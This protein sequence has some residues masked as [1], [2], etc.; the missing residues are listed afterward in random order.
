MTP[1][2]DHRAQRPET[3]AA[4]GTRAGIPLALLLLATLAV[5]MGGSGTARAVVCCGGGGGDTQLSVLDIH[6]YPHSA[7]GTTAG[8]TFEESPSVPPYTVYGS[9]SCTNGCQGGS[10]SESGGVYSIDVSGLVSGGVYSY[11]ITVSAPSCS[12]CVSGKATGSFQATGVAPTYSYDQWNPTDTMS[13]GWPS[14]STYSMT[15]HTMDYAPGDIVYDENYAQNYTSTTEGMDNQ[16]GFYFSSVGACWPYSFSVQSATVEVELVDTTNTND[17]FGWAAASN[18]L[19]VETSTSGQSSYQYSVQASGG[20]GTGS[21]GL[22]LAYTGPTTANWGVSIADANLGGGVW[23]EGTLSVSFPGSGTSYVNVD[24]PTDIND[25]LAKS[26]EWD[27]FEVEFYWSFTL[28]ESGVGCNGGGSDW[29][30]TWS[31]GNIQSV[32]G[33]TG[34]LSSS[35]EDYSS[36]ET[37][38]EGGVPT[39]AYK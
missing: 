26:Y 20:P 30:N 17:N 8:I 6:V 2:G 38:L 27:H 22:G 10:A 7:A 9:V 29:C 11:T 14:S 4:R 31:G 16:V 34:Y 24:W 3:N 1:K 37:F 15:L 35:T 36:Q 5:S 19:Q 23:E 33:N 21:M 18:N 13:C 32:L 25:Q 12:Y 28:G 39:G